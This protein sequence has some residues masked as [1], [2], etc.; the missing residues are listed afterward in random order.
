[1][2]FCSTGPPT[3]F[4]KF[5]GYNNQKPDELKW[6]RDTIF[7]NRIRFAS[8]PELNDPFEGRPR[9]V[10]QH[11]N[12]KKQRA[13][14]YGGVLND[15]HREGLTGEAAVRQATRETEIML[16][17]GIPQQAY[18]KALVETIHESFL[19]YSVCAT[20]EPI[21]MWSHYAVGH[22]GI[23]LHFDPDVVPFKSIYKVHYAK[24]YPQY[25]FP[26]GESF[27]AEEA[28]R[29]MLYTKSIHWCYEEEHRVIRVIAEGTDQERS[30][31]AM[32]LAWDGQV[33]TMPDNALVGVTLGAAMPSNVTAALTAEIEDRRPS[34]EVWQA[35]ADKS[36]YTLDFERVR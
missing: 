26:A 12:P 36:T 32:G 31:R 4:Y 33:V 29:A 35:L 11:K 19:I 22:K 9:L 18:Q 13:A 27:A 5:R 2:R 14:I 17:P 23:A 30:A 10:P 15:A 8:A 3:V 1:M 28:A 20:R 21:L 6:V 25:P 7:E 34:L 24:R 16:A